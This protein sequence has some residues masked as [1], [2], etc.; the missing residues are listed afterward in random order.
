MADVLADLEAMIADMSAEQIAELDTILA[1]ELAQPWLPTPGPQTNAYLSKADLLLYGGAAGGGKTDLIVGLAL[2][3]HKRTV[4]FRRAYGDLK[5]IAERLEEI[6]GSAGL[7]QQPPRYKRGGILIEFG[8][9]EAPKSEM[10]W[11]GIA[12][13]LICFDEGAQLTAAKV[14]FVMGWLRSGAPGHEVRG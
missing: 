2:T 12:H 13:D 4:V 11:Q 5:G 9:L 6:V 7:R 1:E 3:A 14:Q 8:A 10:A